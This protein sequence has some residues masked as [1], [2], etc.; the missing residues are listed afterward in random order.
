MTLPDPE[1]ISWPL[2]QMS[3]DLI[4]QKSPLELWATQPHLRT[5][6]DFLA[7]NI[8]QLGLHAFARQTDGGRERVRDGELPLLLRKP[9]PEQTMFELVREIV[10]DLALH[11][12]AY[13]LVLKVEREDL[14]GLTHEVRSLRPSWVEGTVGADAYGVKGYIVRFPENPDALVVPADRLVVLHG[15]NPADARIGLT[16]VVS[17]KHTLTE[18]IHAAAFRDEMWRRGGRVGSYITRPRP[19]AGESDWSLEARSKFQK[20]FAQNWSAGGSNAGGVPLLEEGMELKRVGFSAKEEQFV[21]ANKLSLATVASVYHVNPTMV[22]LLDNANYANVREFRRMLYGETLGPIIKQIEERI[23]MFLLP[24]LGYTD[25]DLYVEFNVDSR[26]RG[27]Q[28]EQAAVA[29]SAVGAPYITVNE[30]RALQNLPAIDGG[31]VLIQPLNVTQNGDQ[32]PIPAEPKPADNNDQ[33]EPSD[34]N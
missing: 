32:S 16:P 9:N 27:S 14:D 4:M 21:E 20:D 12:I 6:V 29:S 15:W 10:G 2:L 8:A 1:V 25:T 17:L 7:R 26:L 31:D 28:E 11:D 33:E 3:E 22:G 18:Q 19:G 23:N 34:G 24:M 13:L 5:V 30:Y